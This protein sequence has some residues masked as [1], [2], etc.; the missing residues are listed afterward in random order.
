MTNRLFLYGTIFFCLAIQVGVAKTIIVN[1][2]GTVRSIKDAINL[3]QNG[4]TILVM[5]GVYREGNII[6]EKSI[7]LRGDNFPVLDGENK[8][9]IMTIHANGVVVTGFAFKD[10]G[11]ASVN[12]LAAVK[13]LDSKHVKIVGNQFNNTFFGIYLANTT[14]SWIENNQLQANA[15]AEH[16][17]GNGIHLWKCD[18]I[19]INNNSIRG[20]RDGIYF[21]F[22]TNSLITNNHSDRNLRYG[23]HFMFSHNDEYRDNTFINNGA[24]VAVMYTK[25]VTMIGNH[26]EHNWG[27]S[28]YGLLLKDIRDSHVNNNTFIQ[29][30][31]AIFMEG[32]SRTQFKENVF[33]RNGY[34]VKLQASCDDNTFERNNFS[35]NTFDIAT[36]GNMV[37]NTL[38]NNYWDRYEGYDMNR[39]G[40]GDVPF[41]PVSMYAMI[42][43]R[44]PTAVLLWRSFLVFLM[45]RAEKAIPVMTP[46]NLK[47]ESPSM[48]PHDIHLPGK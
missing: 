43:E 10:T 16:Q 27:S 38:S 22:V 34:A 44:I 37:L 36:N 17:M 7:V 29:N 25:N 47:D 32:T 2:S 15:E 12:D 1:P 28:A 46:E 11:V 42:V 40:I 18:Q 8:Y 21:E 20:H 24:G 6:L 5:R 41:R 14:R 35:A 33:S 4:D 13:V 48:R 19:T 9:E 23:L 3:A 30:S 26:F 39:D 45:D 31:T